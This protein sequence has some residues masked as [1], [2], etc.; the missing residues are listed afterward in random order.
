M[1]HDRLLVLRNF[2]KISVNASNMAFTS[3][4]C[5]CI[6]KPVTTNESMVKYKLYFEMNLM[7]ETRAPSH[8][9]EEGFCQFTKVIFTCS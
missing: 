4:R 7:L 1:L 5:N 3:I 8:P 6:N 9:I 2:N